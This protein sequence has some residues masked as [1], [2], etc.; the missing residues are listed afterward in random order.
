[1]H[2]AIDNIGNTLSGWWFGTSRVGQVLP[3]GAAV[4]TDAWPIVSYRCLLMLVMD[5]QSWLQRWTSPENRTGC[6][7]QFL[8]SVGSHLDIPLQRG[9]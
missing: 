5:F 9:Q 2:D 8:Y 6:R 4:P 3:A 1:M 7:Q